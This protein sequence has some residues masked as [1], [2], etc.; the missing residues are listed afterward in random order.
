M[1]V[2]VVTTS[3]NGGGAEFVARTWAGWL[4]AHG[5]DVR[6]VTTNKHDDGT[7]EAGVK[8]IRLTG[9]GP[10]AKIAQL[11]RVLDDPAD[12]VLALQSAPNL[13][14]LSAARRRPAAPAIVVSERNITS[15]EGEPMRPAD[16]LKRAL[17]RRRYRQADLTIAVSHAVAAELVS[18]YGVGGDRIVI[19]PNPAGQRSENR[20]TA[21]PAAAD[22][23]LRLVLPMRLVPQKRAEL[24]V[25]AAALLR[26]RGIDARLLCFAPLSSIPTFAAQAAAADVPLE[27][28]GWVTDW[29]G[30]TPPGSVVVLPS[31]REG[32]GNVLVEAA[33]AG[34]P[35]VA[36]SNAFG[37]ADA[38]IPGLS[39]QLAFT[40]TPEAVADAV[41][42]AQGMPLTRAADWTRRFSTDESGRLLTAALSRAIANRDRTRLKETA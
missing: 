13:M 10:R 5:H 17:A 1:K 36:V 30:E 22:D 37:V 15:R 9:K 27:S 12:V 18:A 19:V 39:G 40:G 4:A 35:S 28:R 41:M 42:A 24:A 8:H 32:F 33:E 26:A 6:I 16:R 29:A 34:I 20:H 3:F 7:A 21:M 23:A 2:I 31:Y 25:A 14:T 38:L 11:R